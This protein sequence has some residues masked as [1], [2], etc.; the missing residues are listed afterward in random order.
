VGFGKAPN[1]NQAFRLHTLLLPSRSTPALVHY[2]GHFWPVH[3]YTM[4]ML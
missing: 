2:P 4:L 3:M 1:G